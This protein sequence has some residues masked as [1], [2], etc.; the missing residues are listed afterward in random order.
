MERESFAA[1]RPPALLGSAGRA[2]LLEASLSRFLA[3][4]IADHRFSPRKSYFV[5]DIFRFF[6]PL[7]QCSARENSSSRNLLLIYIHMH[8]CVS[9]LLADSPF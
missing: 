6:S 2:Y 8:A 1:M 9:F 3:A 7:A 5:V 4:A